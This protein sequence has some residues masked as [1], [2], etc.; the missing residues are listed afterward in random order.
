MRNSG[1]TH[2]GGDGRAVWAVQGPPIALGSWTSVRGGSRA[3]GG[4]S[5]RAGGRHGCD[6]EQWEEKLAWQS[7]SEKGLFGGGP[8]KEMRSAIGSSL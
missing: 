6:G 7:A 1:W 2:V 8:M 3:E 4:S 5:R